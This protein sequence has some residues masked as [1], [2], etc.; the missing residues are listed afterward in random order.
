MNP[1]DE[2]NIVKHSATIQISNNITLLQRKAWN[3][4][5]A[6]AYNNLQNTN[7]HQ[8]NLHDFMRLLDYDSK[9]ISHLKNILRGLV[10][11][12][13]EWNVLERDKSNN[14][15]EEWGIVSLL[16]SVRIVK[17]VIYYAYDEELQKRLYNPKLYAK[18]SMKI[19]NKFNSKHA[20]SLWEVCTD[21]FRDKDNFGET[22]F[23]E[24]VD[25]KK[26]IGVGREQ[27][28][29]FKILNKW[30]IK[31]PV[32]EI[33]K[34]SNLFLV[35]EYKK[36][37]RAV[38]AVKFKIWKNTKNIEQSKLLICNTPNKK[39]PTQEINKK[40]EDVNQTNETEISKKLR[41]YGVYKNSISTLLKQHSVKV[42]SDA[43]LDLEFLAKQKSQTNKPI[44]NM[45]AVLRE[46]LPETGQEYEF[47]DEYMKHQKELEQ[48]EIMRKNELDRMKKEKKEGEERKQIIALEKKVDSFIASLSKDE[49]VSL[50]IEAKDSLKS[51]GVKNTSLGYKTFLLFEIRKETIKKYNIKLED[52]DLT[53][54]SIKWYE[55]IIKQHKKQTEENNILTVSQFEEVEKQ[56]R[57]QA[58]IDLK[59]FPRVTE[60]EINRRAEN[61][62]WD[63]AKKLYGIEI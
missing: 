44:R 21:Y 32:E 61:I 63:I 41:Q 35:V 11:T 25:Y 23:I 36:S 56:A 62:Q 10:S 29:Q 50:E 28:E 6:T 45:G 15:S 59:V 27:Y 26:L 8:I 47:S 13:I 51:R 19:Q 20:L 55:N 49:K 31:D 14:W 5:L 17:G 37:G 9:N 30:A 39:E 16:S 7:K 57:K 18:I 24:I 42:L 34:K 54:E 4:L 12:V 60:K 53:N 38:S 43:I 3:V 40:N 33:N 58:I 48:K 2:K 1:K 52:A 22:P 46:L